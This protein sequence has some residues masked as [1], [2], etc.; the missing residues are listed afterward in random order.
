MAGQVTGTFA[1]GHS[2][3][4][5]MQ[6]VETRSAPAAALIRVTALSVPVILRRSGSLDMPASWRSTSCTSKCSAM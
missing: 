5:T 4:T 3:A 2:E 6:Q 1:A